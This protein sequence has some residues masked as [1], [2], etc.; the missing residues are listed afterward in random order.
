MSALPRTQPTQLLQNVDVIFIISAVGMTITLL[1]GT[2][3]AAAGYFVVLF[4][5]AMWLITLSGVMSKI[6]N[7]IILFNMI[8]T[9]IHVVCIWYIFSSIKIFNVAYD[10]PEEY[11]IYDTLSQILVSSGLVLQYFMAKPLGKLTAKS[12]GYST[13]IMSKFGLAILNSVLL[14]ITVLRIRVFNTYFVITD[15]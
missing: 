3:A 6:K 1:G 9:V 11:K 14:T 15:G 13:E 10:P 12:T 5:Q 4:M 8:I 2:G 7:P